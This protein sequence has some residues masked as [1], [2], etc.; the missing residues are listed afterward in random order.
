MVSYPVCFVM[1]KS[2]IKKKKCSM[3]V[4]IIIFII[5]LFLLPRK[6]KKALRQPCLLEVSFLFNQGSG[7]VMWH[8]PVFRKRGGKKGKGY[9]LKDS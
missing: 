5:Q 9:E 2:R 3:S 4:N 6:R 7:A 8:Q 1:L